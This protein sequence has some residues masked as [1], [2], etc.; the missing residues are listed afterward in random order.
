MLLP[1][2]IAAILSVSV[3]GYHRD[4]LA[5]GAEGK[6]LPFARGEVNLSGRETA[7]QVKLRIG[8]ME[9]VGEGADDGEDVPRRLH[10]PGA[11]CD[12]DAGHLE[13]RAIDGNRRAAE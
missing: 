8:K 2:A 13:I 5:L 4:A 6:D 7:R 9:L 1:S 12:P 11:A 10:S 3:G